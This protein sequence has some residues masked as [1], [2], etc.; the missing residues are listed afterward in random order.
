MVEREIP[1][2]LGK[3]FLQSSPMMKENNTYFKTVFDKFEQKI[4]LKIPYEL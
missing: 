1:G 2:H 3:N 4:S